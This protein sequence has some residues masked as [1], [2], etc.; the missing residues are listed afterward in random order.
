MRINLGLFWQNTQGVKVNA[1]EHDAK[2]LPDGIA[3]YLVKHGHAIVI[4]EQE[5]IVIAKHSTRPRRKKK[6]S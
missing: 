5:P 4:E 2:D 1:G 3:E 6:T